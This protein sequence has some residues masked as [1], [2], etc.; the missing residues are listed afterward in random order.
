MVKYRYTNF[1]RQNIS[2]QAR[3]Q[4]RR[5]FVNSLHNF[6]AKTTHVFL[7]FYMEEDVGRCSIA[8]L[9]FTIGYSS[10]HMLI[11]ASEPAEL[12]IKF[13]RVTCSL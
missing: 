4:R 12:A 11:Q 5:N 9:G 10:L 13:P 2:G 6:S 7:D 1:P 3:R 8:Q